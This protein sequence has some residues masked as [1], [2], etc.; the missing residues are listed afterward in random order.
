MKEVEN[1]K[2]AFFGTP[3]SRPR[4]ITFVKNHLV[5]ESLIY[6]PF[7]HDI[8]AVTCVGAPDC[9]TGINIR[10]WTQKYQSTFLGQRGETKIQIFIE[11]S[12]FLPYTLQRH[13]PW[14]TIYI[15]LIYWQF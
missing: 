11:R 13:F 14:M 3:G 2:S 10:P 4:D 7:I 1:R 12:S 9:I 15:H 8:I 5:Q 6:N